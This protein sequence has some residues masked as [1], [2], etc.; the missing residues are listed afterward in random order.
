MHF[1]PRSIPV[2]FTCCSLHFTA[3]AII[4]TYWT[5]TLRHCF[6]HNLFNLRLSNFPK[7]TPWLEPGLGLG[8][9][10]AEPTLFLA[11]VPDV[12]PKLVGSHEQGVWGSTL[13][14]PAPLL[15]CTSSFLLKSVAVLEIFKN[16]LIFTSWLLVIIC[17][18]L[19][20]GIIWGK[21]W[22]NH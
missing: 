19:V 12:R 18:K 9:L 6:N 16:T 1:N 7:M 2:R 22:L 13:Y 14:L 15:C 4:N 11:R 3:A 10:A 5:F 21:L 17:G 8:S 20:L